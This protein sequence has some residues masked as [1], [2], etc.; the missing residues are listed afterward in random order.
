MRLRA[1]E[2]KAINVKCLWTPA[3]P[4]CRRMWS[5]KGGPGHVRPMKKLA[6][7]GEQHG[8]NSTAHAFLVLFASSPSLP[9]VLRVGQLLLLLCDC[10]ACPLNCSDARGPLQHLTC[11]HSAEMRDR[12][13]AFPCT[14]HA[15]HAQEGRASICGGHVDGI[16]VLESRCLQLAAHMERLCC[17]AGR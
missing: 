17:R 7:S 10:N 9:V 5:R 2:D 12:H 1:R 13:T 3:Q 4:S 8:S 14:V 15:G 6:I 11:C 16:L